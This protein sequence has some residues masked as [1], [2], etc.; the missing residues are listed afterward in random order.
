[1]ANY[2]VYIT[3]VRHESY[4]IEQRILAEIGAEM[5]PCNCSSAEEII[6]NCAD[7]DGL[8]LDLAPCNAEAIQGLQHCKV[9]NRYGAGYDNVDI[10]AATAK[11]I[12]VT[13]VPDYCMEDVSDHALALM[14]SCLRQVAYRD[15]SIRNGK[16][17][18]Q[19][20]GFRLAGKT[21]G[22]LGF[23]RIARAFVKKCSGFGFAHIL[24]YDP[25][26]SEEV[27]SDLGVEKASMDDVLAQSDFLSLHMAVTPETH[28]MLNA[29]ALSKMKPTA[30][31]VNVTRGQLV[32]DEALLDALKN[33]K[34]LAAGLDTHNQE[35]L[36]LESPFLALDNVILTDHTAYNTAEGVVEL[37]TKAAQN[38]VDVLSG[39][40]PVY[41]VNQL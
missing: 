12:Q 21:L 29:Q 3:D 8:L 40:K 9:I 14:L 39:R 5:I 4:E 20:Q 31:L 33:G 26:V 28:G 37:K 7:A 15:H 1:M 11:G 36:S 10:E 19:G 34:I 25:Y 22:V 2:K 24:A 18:I 30:I 13:Y 35:P 17:N 27:M 32:D 38:I 23:G 6:K 16:W 41:P